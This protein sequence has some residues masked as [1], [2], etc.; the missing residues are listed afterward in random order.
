MKERTTTTPD[1]PG[2]QSGRLRRHPLQAVLAAAGA[3]FGVATI[4]AGG[5]T[6]TGLG[7]PGYAIF[8]PLLVF[9]T[10]MGFGYVAAGV[11]IWRDVRGGFIAAATIV[12]LNVAALV[13]V[14]WAYQAGADVA[15]QSLGA[16]GFRTA[17]W[18]G[19]WSGVGWLRMRDGEYRSVA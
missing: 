9:N 8:M 5:R 17:V 4:A 12:A 19:I 11:A 1:R 18:L 13:A 2:F 10:V 15:S 7:D 14:A 16:M 6:L 3:L